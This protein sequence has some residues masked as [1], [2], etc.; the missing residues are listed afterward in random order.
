M[1]C[2][3]LMGNFYVELGWEIVMA[4][5]VDIRSVSMEAPAHQ[6]VTR[7]SAHVLRYVRSL[8]ITHADA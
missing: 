3:F 8:Y 6:L 7:L 1:T 2:V 4:P 5:H